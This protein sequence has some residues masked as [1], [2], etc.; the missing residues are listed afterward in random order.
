MN[1]KIIYGPEL[2]NKLILIMAL[3]PHNMQICAVGSWLVDWMVGWLVGR[4]VG[5]LVGWLVGSLVSHVTSKNM[6]HLCYCFSIGVKQNKVSDR[7]SSYIYQS[8]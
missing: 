6:L 1:C 2:S 7:L 8:D 5:W 3:S 4:L